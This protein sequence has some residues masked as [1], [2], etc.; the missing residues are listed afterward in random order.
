MEVEIVEEEQEAKE[1]PL[2]NSVFSDP[3]SPIRDVPIQGRDVGNV[4]ETGATVSSSLG[5][6]TALVRKLDMLLLAP[7]QGCSSKIV[8][9]GMCLL[10]DDVENISSYLAELS[11]VEDPPLSAK[12]WMNEVRDLSYD[13]EDYIDNLI[14]VQPEDPSLVTNN[15]KIIRSLRK[16]SSHVK[17]PKK[18]ENIVETLSEFRM[19]IQ[20]A[21]ERHQRYNLHP[22]RTLRRRFVSLGPMLLPTPYEETRDIVIDGRMN[23]FINSLANDGD[24]QLK[25]VSVLGSACLGKTTLA[26]V[27]YNRFVKQY[28]CRAFIRV[29]KKPDMK[30]IFRDMLWQIQR[31]DP[32]QQHPPQHYQEI[33]LVHNIKKYLQDKRYLIIIDDVWAASVWDIINH[34]F[35][36]GNHGSRIITTTQIKDVALACCCD[37]PEYVFEMKHLDDDHSRKLFFNRLFGSESDCP[38][39]LKV[40][41]NE[42]VEICDG[43]PLATISIASL[44]ASQP[45]MSIDL[46]EYIHQSLSSCFSAME[47]TR[48]A[49]NLSFSNLPHYLKTCLL[50][51]VMNPEGYTFCN[52]D[53]VKQ[54]VAEG[55]I[56]RMKGQ[57]M[58]KV[59]ESYLDQLISRRFI[60]PICNDYN[61]KVLSSAVHDAVYDLIAHKS[62]E[63]NFILAID[64]SQ[65]NVSLSHKVRRLSLLFGDARSA[66]TPA[67]IRKSEVRSLRF[68]GLFEC[69]PCIKEFKLI[70]VLNLQ[71]Y[72]HDDYADQ[73]RDLTAISEL[74]QLRYLKIACDVYINLPNHGL[75][76]LETLDIMDARVLVPWNI[77]LPHLLHLSL[78]LEEKLLYW[79]G[80]GENPIRR[81]GG[82]LTFLQEIH[83][84]PSGH[85]LKNSMAVLGFLIGG[86]GN[87]K[88]VV[89]AC[90]SSV[91]NIVVR[92]ASKV[93]ISWDGLAPPPLLQRFE[94]S[95]RSGIIFSRIPMWFKELGNLRILKIAVREIFCLE[96]LRGLP[97][98][99]AL[100]LYLET[101]PL[102]M[103][104]FD[105]A[106]EFSVLKYFKLRCTSGIA[107]LKFEADAMPN[108]WKLKL[109]FNNIPSLYS[110][111]QG[112]C[113]RYNGGSAVIS[114]EHMPSLKEISVKFGGAAAD[115][116][117][118]LSTFVSNHPSNPTINLQLVGHTYYGDEST[119]Q[120]EQPDEYQ[121]QQ[122]D[123]ILK[124]EPDEYDRTL[125]GPADKRI[126]IPPESSSRLHVPAGA[127]DGSQ[128]IQ[129]DVNWDVS[130]RYLPKRGGWHEFTLYELMSATSNFS[131]ENLLSE[132]DYGHIYKGS[133]DGKLMI[134]ITKFT[135]GSRLPELQYL[136]T[137]H[138]PH[139][140]RLLGYCSQERHNILVYEYMPRGSLK[141]YLGETNL[142]TSLPWLTRLKIAVGAAK[143]LSFL[144][145]SGKR[146]F[147]S[148]FSASSILLDSDYTAKLWG[149]GLA[150]RYDMRISESER[151]K[152]DLS[153]AKA[154]RGFGGAAMIKGRGRAKQADRDAEEP[155]TEAVTLLTH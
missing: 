136:V 87:L 140:V 57:D 89:V 109:V 11:E 126:S 142:I 79:I 48:Q 1:S 46:L 101:A 147:Y 137:T 4:R 18:Q 29:S 3:V 35:P 51:L 19:Y 63:E 153:K 25:V 33:D 105:T 75:E 154:A 129:L 123:N 103:I 148:P 98:L 111:K 139:M 100:S 127:G 24:Q 23:G 10:K 121:K 134:A 99:A 93:I 88:T 8:K 146:R 122:P 42:I 90:F 36:K 92:V 7:P 32:L 9:D 68:F 116:E 61:N 106:D 152:S 50:Y 85:N 17:T 82:R 26:R 56:N 97:A 45:V 115:V 49:L 145:D 94:L 64:Y 28:C 55:F 119:M 143:G 6:M 124:G 16:L 12:C 135:Y 58:V 65:K 128:S 132:A 76:C 54:W 108:L 13:M 110:S 5:A 53:T 52:D 38:E 84:T 133:L 155:T 74:F 40:V 95:P 149:F 130:S 114:I 125:E 91:E 117:C 150:K 78:P 34:A 144:Q 60:Q 83:L 112:T 131:E 96:I 67:N 31:L 71:I 120:K 22:C 21:I 62:A 69:M 15:T 81:S 80:R 27:L 138:H 37:Q 107:W 113:K 66:K 39:Q 44:L 2:L 41:L 30:R 77:H 86:H 102:R 70:R 73:V 72:T 151:R 20:E 141:H 47:K 104:I 59:A 118:A 14:V 43:L